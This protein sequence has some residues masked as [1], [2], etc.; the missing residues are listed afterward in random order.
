MTL[1]TVL[2]YFLSLL[3]IL[4]ITV[5]P[6]RSLS[7]KEWEKKTGL[8]S[9]QQRKSDTVGFTKSQHPGTFD[10]QSQ[11]WWNT[12]KI[13]SISVGIASK[14]LK[15][16]TPSQQWHLLDNLAFTTSLWHCCVKLHNS[17]QRQLLYQTLSN[18][19]QIYGQL[20]KFMKRIRLIDRG[21]FFLC[22]VVQLLTRGQY[23]C[24]SKLVC[25]PKKEEAK[26]GSACAS[27]VPV[28][29]GIDYPFSTHL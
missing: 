27:E 18:F 12:K 26:Q 13:W 2:L 14:F 9:H 7:S 4:I 11:A 21:A 5:I 17:K 16:L 19:S 8:K 15:N 22:F 20:L 1:S 25:Q 3:F 23:W 10:G 6:A 28:N 29:S 24:T